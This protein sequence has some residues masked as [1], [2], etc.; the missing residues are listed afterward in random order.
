MFAVDVST[1]HTAA[2][3]FAELIREGRFDRADI[4]ADHAFVLFGPAEAVV[5]RS[6]MRDAIA[7]L[8]RDLNALDRPRTTDL[9]PSAPRECR[10]DAF[11]G[12]VPPRK[13]RHTC[14]GPVF[15][16]L[17]EGCPRCDELARGAEPVRWHGTRR[18][19]R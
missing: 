18:H 17:T 12:T 16:R 11:A 7:D 4:L 10:P 5:F 6:L 15:G 1:P 13:A 8:A 9:C 3:A 14:G 2:A 19:Y